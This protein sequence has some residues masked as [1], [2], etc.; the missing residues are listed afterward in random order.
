[1]G[2]YDVKTPI[3]VFDHWCGRCE[4][5]SYADADAHF[6]KAK[7]PLKGKPL[8]TWALLK[9]DDGDYVVHMKHWNAGDAEIGR[10]HPDNTFEFTMDTPE[11]RRFSATLSQAMQKALPF[12]WFRMGTG[13]YAVTPTMAAFNKVLSLKTDEKKMFQDVW[14]IIKQGTIPVSKGLRID[15]ATG[16]ALN[17]QP[18][19]LT[20]VVPEKRKEW[21]RT[22]RTYKRSIKVKARLGIIDPL[23]AEVARERTGTSR[24]SWLKPDWFS[25]YWGEILYTAVK[26]NDTSTSMLKLFVQSSPHYFHRPAR[27][28]DILEEVEAIFRQQSVSLRRRFGVFG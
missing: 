18:D 16:K 27:T 8:R 2:A 13:R 12:T 11:M 3:D 25:E 21:L 5:R 7:N 20:Q 1:M 6:A 14:N 15:L 26:N 17:A 9:Y 22:L 4:L 10:F 28:S 23:I 24:N 19:I